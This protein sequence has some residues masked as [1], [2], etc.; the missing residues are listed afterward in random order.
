[1]AV[2]AEHVLS[3]LRAVQDPDLKRDIVS[4]GF[5]KGVTIQGGRVAFTIE[6]TTPACPVREQLKEQ[7]RAAVQALP[8]ISQVD[9]TMTSQVRASLASQPAAR[10][11]PSVKNIIPVASGKGGVGKST[12]TANLA[13][14]LAQRGARVGVMDADV[15]GPSLPTILGVHSTPQVDE[16]RRITPVTRHELKVI[17]MGFF[18]KPEEAVVWRG[19]MLHKTV[20]QFLGGVEW[21]ELD[22]LLC[23]MPPGCLTA[24]TLVSTDRGPVRISDLREGSSVYSFDGHLNKGRSQSPLELHA[25][26]VRRKVLAVIPQGQQPVYEL[27]TSTRT[28][29]GTKDHPIL[30]VHRDKRPGTRVHTYSLEWR[31]LGDLRPR[32]I[33]L[34]V[35]KLPQD[36][37]R[38]LTLPRLEAAAKVY[39]H[40]PEQTSD[41][42]LRLIGYFLGDGTVRTMANGNYW[43]VW[44]SEPEG[45][46]YRMRYIKSIQQLFDLA[47]VHKQPMK[48]AALSNQVAE[49]FD[50]LELHK[51]ALDKTVPAWV[52]TLPESQKVALIEGFCDADGHRRVAR[53]GH[54][55]A[56]WM[57]FESPNKELM[58]GVRALCL[59][60]GFK[61]GN[62]RYRTRWTRLPSTG[63]FVKRTFYDFE[64][65][66]VAKTDLYGAGL[67][68][69][70]RVGRGLR[71]EYMGF[72]R[73]KSVTLAGA[74]EVYDLQVEG[75]HN[76]VANG[77]IVHNTGD[78]QLSLCQLIP[79]TG[80][81]IV[82]TPQDVALNVAQKAIAMFRK[83]N[84][85]VLGII[86]NM[87]AHV[88]RS[89][90]TRDDI[91]GSGGAKAVAERLSIPFLG[92]I[93]L[94]TLI[95][96]TSDAGTPIVLTH[97]DSS[98]AKAFV[99][100]AEQLAAQVSIRAM[101]GEL[102]PHV[103][104]T[105]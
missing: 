87:S 70:P 10:L 7:A 102:A 18:M 40:I 2:T 63:R 17:S 44:F 62:L 79:I 54:R 47:H 101:Q 96:E 9:V 88:C 26:L 8:G 50:K 67:I 83:L 82:S 11:A 12:V 53:V 43:G 73:V 37:G 52:F 39:L 85:P 66:R 21:G 104:V 58:G 46:A 41:E 94:D 38:S 93:P 92:E 90:G 89:C 42:L 5:V 16:Q 76:F 60:V 56:G 91:F 31:K 105:F 95:R 6:L 24:E 98:A 19:P 57:C 97:P 100:A 13:L 65:N 27:R 29:V 33:I 25:A 72:E 1:M 61:V 14:A 45:G 86:E 103:K 3:A 75:Q 36:Q 77:L 22:Y 20:E 34:V 35:K 32:D 51:R 71:H 4:L 59:D 49:L 30:A 99:N 78:V 23:D 80:A 84:A 28:I 81:V 68:R 55:R 15:Y 48:F 74:A 69:G 64:A